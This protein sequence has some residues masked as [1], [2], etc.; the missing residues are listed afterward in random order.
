MPYNIINS[1]FF[2]TKRKKFDSSRN[3]TNFGTIRTLSMYQSGIHNSASFESGSKR[4]SQY[5]NIRGYLPKYLFNVQA[6]AGNKKLM[7]L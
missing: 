3:E 5:S 7:N 1:N 2:C 6:L 4:A